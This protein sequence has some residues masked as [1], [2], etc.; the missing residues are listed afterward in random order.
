MAFC[1]VPWHESR[2][3]SAVTLPSPALAAQSGADCTCRAHGTTVC[4]TEL[5]VT[6]TVSCLPVMYDGQ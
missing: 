4:D 5:R 1:L 2:H 3:P 6:V